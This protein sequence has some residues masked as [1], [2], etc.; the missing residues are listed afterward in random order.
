MVSNSNGTIGTGVWPVNGA[1][2]TRPR[3]ERAPPTGGQRLEPPPTGDIWMGHMDG[4]TLYSIGEPARRTGLSVRTIR[5]Y[6]DAGVV[7]PTSRS[8]AGYRL[9]DLDA[10]LHLAL[11]RTLRELGIVPRHDSASAG[12]RTVGRGSRRGACRRRGPAD[13]TGDGSGNVGQRKRLLPRLE[14]ATFPPAAH[15]EVTPRRPART[16]GRP[17][18]HEGTDAAGRDA[19]GCRR[20]SRVARHEY[21]GE[22]AGGWTVLPG[23]RRTYCLNGCGRASDGTEGALPTPVHP[24]TEPVRRLRAGSCRAVMR[25]HPGSTDATTSPVAT[26]RFMTYRSLHPLT[27]DHSG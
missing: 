1:S 7:A 15:R 3:T 8:R 18:S 21:R 19:A 26:P 27:P 11:V 2:T 22:P 24:A 10:L 23:R 16:A 20:G 17:A 25:L 4:K 13:P 14:A 5:F 9:Y 6:S 12:P